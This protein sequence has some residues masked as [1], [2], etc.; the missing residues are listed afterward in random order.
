MD[1]DS[2]T[3]DMSY[4]VEQQLDGTG[5]VVRSIETHPDGSQMV[6]EYEEALPD[7][8]P[9]V[10]SRRRPI[11]NDPPSE[12][13]T[14]FLPSPERP[15]TYPAGFP[16]LA[17]RASHTTES[18]ARLMSPGARWPCNDPEMVLAALV[19]TCLS[20][21]WTRVPESGIGATFRDN[22]AAAFR[23]GEDVRLF[24]RFDHEGGSVIQMVD[25]T[26]E[27]RPDQQ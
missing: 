2:E 15:Q 10:R 16:F 25:L 8:D 14:E 6:T 12:I 20:D 5:R 13:V 17:G 7:N 19:D 27:G 9:Y 26:D 21:G 1:D 4:F 23:R 18:P 11:G 22:L 3:F 24:H